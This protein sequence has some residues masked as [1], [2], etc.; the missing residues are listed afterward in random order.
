MSASTATFRRGGQGGQARERGLEGPG[1]RI[2]GI[3][4][5]A[6]VAGPT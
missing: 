2:V 5:D 6:Q 1:I 4:V 3:V